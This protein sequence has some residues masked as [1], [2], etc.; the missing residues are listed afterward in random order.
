M[1]A[2]RQYDSHRCNQSTAGNYTCGMLPTHYPI[3]RQLRVSL[4]V[5]TTLPHSIRD[6]FDVMENQCSLSHRVL[7]R[8][9]RK[10][11]WDQPNLT[12]HKHVL[13]DENRLR[14]WSDVR[15]YPIAQALHMKCGSLGR[16]RF[17][18][19]ETIELDPHGR[20]K[21]YSDTGSRRG[22][23]TEERGIYFI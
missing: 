16:V 3:Y 4:P 20:R 9:K 12:G 19:R 13:V 14:V 23:C 1:G 11:S 2:S 18:V 5:S 22:A 8:R 7:G 15:Q 21:I 10:A 17:W 6:P